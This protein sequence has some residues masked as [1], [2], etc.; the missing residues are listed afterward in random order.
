MMGNSIATTSNKMYSILE[1]KLIKETKTS[2]K[3]PDDN[4]QLFFIDDIHLSYKDSWG[5]QGACELIRQWQD[6]HGWFNTDKIYFK[7]VKEINFVASISTRKTAQEQIDE[8]LSWHFS[9]IGVLRFEGCHLEQIYRFILGKA[10]IH[11]STKSVQDASPGLV[12]KASL[13][14]YKN[15]NKILKPSPTNYLLRINERHLFYLLKGILDAP[16]NYF[17]RIEN[18]A[19]MWVNEVCRTVLDRHTDPVEHEK[20]YKMLCDIACNVFTIQ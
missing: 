8:R 11:T 18:V 2:L 5:H 3:P 14:F 20:M 16:G 15:Y 7:K 9:A 10:F 19:L 1:N 6:F 12:L 17:Q 4:H 13:E